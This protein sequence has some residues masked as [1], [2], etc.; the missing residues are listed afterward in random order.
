MSEINGDMTVHTQ[1]S[2]F[3][4]VYWKRHNFNNW[5]REWAQTVK[6]QMPGKTHVFA[7]IYV[8]MKTPQRADFVKYVKTFNKGG[9]IT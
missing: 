6:N 3:V 9:K 4:K 8:E 7:N 2:I 1:L 5:S